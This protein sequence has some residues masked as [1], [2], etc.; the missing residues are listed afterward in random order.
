MQPDFLTG[1]YQT[2]AAFIDP[3]QMADFAI[4]RLYNQALQWPARDWTVAIRLM[5]LPGRGRLF[6]GDETAA[7]AMSSGSGSASPADT[8]DRLLAEFLKNP[9]FKVTLADR[10]Y[11][12]LSGQGALTD[13]VAQARW[14]ALAQTVAP[15]IAVDAVRWP[16]DGSQSD[17]PVMMLAPGP[18]LAETVLAQAR[19]LGYYPPLDPPQFSRPGGVVETGDSITLSLPIAAPE[20]AIHYTTNATDPRLPVTGEIMPTAVIYQQPVAIEQTLTLKAR[21]RCPGPSPDDPATWSALQEAV[22]TVVKEDNPLRL[23]EIMYNPLGGDNFEFVELQNVGQTDLPLANISLDDGLR[24]TF[25]PNA[26]LLAP[27]QF[28]VLVSNAEGFAQRYPDVPIAG[29]YE[30]HLSNKGERIVLRDA[31]FEELMSVTYDDENGWPV[32][33][34]GRGDS[35]VL[36]DPNADPT[37]PHSWRASAQVYGSP[38]RAE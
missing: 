35:L 34:D 17:S 20:C 8:A 3:V 25:P 33:P 23:T 13:G 1:L 26:P 27:G 2:T 10:L 32:S 36:I 37:N 14:Q 6:M 19:R 28:A 12:H 15:A 24:F 5:D 38:G 11:K 29:V 21:L 7:T 18:G 9:D 16:S 4:L 31:N 30:G 22:F